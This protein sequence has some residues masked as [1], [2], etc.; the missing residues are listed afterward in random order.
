MN[1]CFSLSIYIKYIILFSNMILNA[2]YTKF[3]I[4]CVGKCII[5]KYQQ[6]NAYC[7]S[8]K[9]LEI[10]NQ[11][12]FS[13][14]GKKKITQR[15]QISPSSWES[16]RRFRGI[17]KIK[18]TFEMKRKTTTQF[19]RITHFYLKKYFYHG[20]TCL[21][22]IPYKIVNIFNVFE[23]AKHLQTTNAVNK[24]ASQRLGFRRGVAKYKFKGMVLYS[25]LCNFKL[26]LIT[27]ATLWMQFRREQ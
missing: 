15:S 23:H 4:K 12:Y 1:L 11:Q 26:V 20:T 3:Y 5:Y 8:E 2:N 13:L 14:G 6:I 21:T 16:L 22:T 10:K 24:C 9:M 25:Y 17:A 7:L 27:L 18:T 19:L